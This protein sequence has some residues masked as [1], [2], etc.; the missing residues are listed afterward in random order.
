MRSERTERWSRRD[1]VRR[2]ALAGTAGVVGLRSAPADAEPPPETTR[3]RIGNVGG[4]CMAPEY[5]AEE[6][7]RSEG[8][9]DVK[10]VQKAGRVEAQKALA[11]G[12]VAIQQSA[13]GP[14]LLQVE[15]GDPVVLL[16][17]VHVGC[18]A[19]FGTDRVRSIRDLKG[20]TVSV[21]ELGTGRHVFLAS[22]MAWV[23]L[24]P[25]KDV[26][27]AVHSPAESIRLL[28]EGKID[29]Y[30]AFAEEVQ[31]LRARK[32]GRVILDSTTD[33]PWSQYF[34]CFAAVNRGFARRNPVASKRALRAILKATN[35]C[36]LEP[37]RAARFLVDRGYA[38]DYDYV[39][40]TLKALPY[41]RWRDADP[42]DTLRFYAL[43][44][45]EVGMIK[46]SPQKIL[47]EGTDWRF[48][49]ELKK[50]L[51]G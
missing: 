5:V 36:A 20:K 46:T 19:L 44:L 8:F 45:H 37:D 26:T 27:F 28:A 49:N 7:L 11:S 42:E 41:T 15:E 29:A 31:E 4:A 50:E 21:T 40:Q 13:V 24:D 23:G 34:C 22:A 2:L 10:Y 38:T 33:R 1:F 32:I 12:E 48:L 30:Q 35:V 18:F 16:A 43:R 6:L 39:V 47:A 25:R 3:L 51:K 17:G 14:L 9:T